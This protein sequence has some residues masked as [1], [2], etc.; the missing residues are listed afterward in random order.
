MEVPGGVEMRLDG[1]TKK[2][3]ISSLKLKNLSDYIYI[4]NSIIPP[5]SS[6]TTELIADTGCSGHY[7]GIT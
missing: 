3:D 1:V 6:K 7:N 4:A 5:N 2:V